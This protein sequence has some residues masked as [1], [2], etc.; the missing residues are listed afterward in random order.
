[1][2]LT[3]SSGE[4]L[5]DNDFTGNNAALLDFCGSGGDTGLYV[6]SGSYAE[7]VDGSFSNNGNFG[8]YV[9][10]TIDWQVEE[11]ASCTSNAIYFVTDH[12]PISEEITRTSCPILPD[13]YTEESLM[14]G[15]VISED[16]TLTEP[17][18]CSGEY[19]YGLE[20]GAE[21]IT[22]DCNGWGISGSGFGTGIYVNAYSRVTVKNCDISNFNNGVEIYSSSDSEINKNNIHN[23]Q[24]N[25]IYVDLS[26][27][28]QILDNGIRNNDGFGV[29][30]EGEDISSGHTIKGNIINGN[31]IECGEEGCAGILLL[32]EDN[33]VIEDNEVSRNYYGIVLSQSY[34]NSVLNNVLEGNFH[35]GIA[36]FGGNNNDI[37][38]NEITDSGNVGIWI[39]SNAEDAITNNVIRG[40]GTFQ[41]RSWE[42]SLGVYFDNENGDA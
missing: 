25:G 33:C 22:I 34:D 15:D 35:S 31:N 16:L 41:G 42:V 27:N 36:L 29:F 39:R 30:I 5:Y 19:T 11:E 4:Y 2:R 9:E 37:S 24:D 38:G 14:C 8:I 40:D 3:A 17:L 6:E 21:D 13:E 7:I 18:I 1:M 10:G 20:I 28:L 12:D 26:D 32:G 23:N